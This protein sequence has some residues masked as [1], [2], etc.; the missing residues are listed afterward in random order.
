MKKNKQELGVFV[1]DESVGYFQ[2]NQ[3]DPQAS[4]RGQVKFESGLIENGY[5]VDA[6]GFFL[7][8]KDEFKDKLLK[9]SKV[10]LVIHEQNV[11]IRELTIKKTELQKKSIETYLL[12]QKGKVLHYPF[13]SPAISHHVISESPEEFSVLVFICDQKLLNDYYDIFERLGVKDLSFDVPSMA[14]YQQY[15]KKTEYNLANT[16]LVLVY[17]RMLSI[18]IIENGNPIFSM[19][20][21]CDGSGDAFYDTIENYIER[22]ANYYRYNL[23]KDKSSIYNALIFNLTE[24]IEQPRFI[25]KMGLRL[26]A[27]ITTLVDLNEVDPLLVGRPKSCYVP[28]ASS[29]LAMESPKFKFN[30]NIDRISK[31]RL[32]AN[33]LLV[34]ALAIFSIV[35]LLYIPYQTLQSSI[36]DQQN[37]ND[38]LNHLLDDLVSELPNNETHSPTEIDYN[39]V[40]D[41]I[42]DESISPTSKLNDLFG[43]L[44]GTVEITHYSINSQDSEITLSISATSESDLYEYLIDIYE[45]YGII[46]GVIDDSRWIILQPSYT[47]QSAF[48]MEVTILYA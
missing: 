18:H 2:L 13:L 35:S 33:Y 38:N 43:L 45:T 31:S 21:E 22:I 36:N 8:L 20:E 14:L 41:Y 28:F 27:F 47:L 39:D 9:P 44:S 19:I 48:V 11:L 5:I 46:E 3:K 40:Y 12:E 42:N 24:R 32:Y 25:E 4:N 1:T 26:N 30:F 23:R 34:L 16:L 7:L 6:M 29:K 15:T 17:E 10:R 37:V